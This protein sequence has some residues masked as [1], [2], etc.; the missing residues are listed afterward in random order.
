MTAFTTDTT[1]LMTAL[2]ELL[3]HSTHL[4]FARSLKTVKQAATQ[5]GINLKGICFKSLRGLSKEEITQLQTQGNHAAAWQKIKVITD[6]IPDY[7]HNCRFTG[8]CILGRFDGRPLAAE[9][10]IFLPNGLYDSTLSEV[11]IGS[12]ALIYRV[13]L[14]ANYWLADEVIIFQTSSLTASLTDSSRAV[15]AHC[16]FGNGE[17][18]IIGRETGG[19]EVSLFAEMD[20]AVAS[21]LTLQRNNHT[22]LEEYNTFLSAY[23]EAASLP[24]G[25]VDKGSIIRHSGKI[26]DTFV[27]AGSLIDNASLVHNS[28]LLGSASEPVEIS[29]GAQVSH[30]CLQ[31]GCTVSSQALV[32]HALLTEHT[33][34]ERQGKVTMSI[35]GPNTGIG[36]GEVTSSLVGPFVGFHHQALLIAALWPAGKGNIGYGANVGSNHTGKAPDQELLCGEGLFWGLGVNIKYPANFS[37]APY[38][39][40]ATGVDTLPQAV[41]FP[42]S[43]INKPAQL[44]PELSPSYNEI[45]PGWVLSENSYLILRNEEKYKK[46][47]RAR[48]TTISWR[49]FRPDIIE[50]LTTAAQNLERA[51]LNRQT[52][53]TDKELPGLGK[54]Y[55]T[56]AS[57]VNGLAAY[58]FFIEYYALQ[59]LCTCLNNYCNEQ[60][61]QQGETIS[62]QELT[63]VLFKGTAQAEETG[64]LRRLWLHLGIDKRSIQGSL[65]RLIELQET[66]ARRTRQAKERDDVRGQKIMGEDYLKQGLAAGDAVIK[67]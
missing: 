17:Q 25:V 22:F 29:H 37:Q 31:W 30:S 48:R 45:F 53:Y 44:Y 62:I 11:A 66:L 51:G 15:S 39:I 24:F 36:E 58:S 42:F 40:V 26:S 49:I 4:E 47:N 9:T 27:G 28:T 23:A 63:R 55:M 5:P 60:P 6:F 33:H 18:L 1:K 14:L 41:A 43:L 50:L 20:F 65:G 3:N 52:I 13:G 35:I 21:A 61:P 54:N 59:G 64:Y 46:R 19:R 67:R 32:D 56:E 2:N 12:N 34:V 8:E 16:R 10:S 7:I 38:T 57:R